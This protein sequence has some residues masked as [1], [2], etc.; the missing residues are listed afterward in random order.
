MNRGFSV[1]FVAVFAAVIAFLVYR[2]S[3]AREKPVRKA[4]VRR[5]RELLAMQKESPSVIEELRRNLRY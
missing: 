4:T 1:G 3:T 5:L 2:V